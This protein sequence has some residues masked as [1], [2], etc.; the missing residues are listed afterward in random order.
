MMSLDTKSFI[1]LGGGL[2]FTHTPPPFRVTRDP[3]TGRMSTH[4]TQTNCTVFPEDIEV[5]E[6]PRPQP[7]VEEAVSQNEV[8]VPTS[9]KDATK[10]ALAFLG[11]RTRKDLDDLGGPTRSGLYDKTKAYIPSL[12]DVPKDPKA[13]VRASYE[14]MLEGYKIYQ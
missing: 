9:F 11:I 8:P 3:T 12:W 6:F 7:F 5:A 4:G 13:S 10:S 1:P 2:S 14:R